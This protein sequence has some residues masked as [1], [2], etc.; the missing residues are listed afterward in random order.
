MP[1]LPAALSFVLALVAVLGS[2]SAA[3]AMRCGNRLVQRGDSR[4]QVRQLCGEPQDVVRSQALRQVT[5]Q[6]V[7]GVFD[8]VAQ[9]V[10]VERWTYDFGPNRFQRHLVFE[11]G[12]LVRITTGRKGFRPAPARGV[13]AKVA[14]PAADAGKA[15]RPRDPRAL[16]A[17]RRG[18]SIHRS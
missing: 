7:P 14:P 8:T 3:E 13:G 11:N 18:G 16:V 1:R 17:R 5:L 12:T 15:L 10:P 2:A 6:V 9:A 4:Y